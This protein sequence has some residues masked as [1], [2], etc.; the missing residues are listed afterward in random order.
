MNSIESERYRAFVDLLRKQGCDDYVDLPQIA[1]VGDQ[2]SGKSSVLSA[3][4]DSFSFLPRH[5][6]RD[7]RRV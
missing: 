5:S 4:A 1:V 3:I 7:A 6:R 2:S